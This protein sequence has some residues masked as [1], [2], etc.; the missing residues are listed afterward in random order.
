VYDETFVFGSF[1]LISAQ[2]L[3]LDDGKPLGP[4][5]HALNILIT[6]LEGDRGSGSQGQC[7][8]KVKKTSMQLGGNAPFFVF[9]DADFEMAVKGA[10]AS[11]NR[12]PG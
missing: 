7:A 3:L 9:D 8:T 2:P 4:G 11:K 10:I 1:Q 12:N 6:L 5:G